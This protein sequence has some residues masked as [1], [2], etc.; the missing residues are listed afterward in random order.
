M[1]INSRQNPADRSSFRLSLLMRMLIAEGPGTVIWKRYAGECVYDRS[2]HDLL[3][4]ILT[5]YSFMPCPNAHFSDEFKAEV[6]ALVEML[7]P[8]AEN[9]GAECEKSE[10][11]QFFSKLNVPSVQHIRKL[12]QLANESK[13]GTGEQSYYAK[14]L[15]HY[16]VSQSGPIVICGSPE[17]FLGYR[18]QNERVSEKDRS[19]LEI[20]L[21]D[22]GYSKEF[23]ISLASNETKKSCLKQ[24]PLETSYAHCIAENF[25]DLGLIYVGRTSR[26]QL[27]VVLAGATHP[28]GT[29]GSVRMAM[30]AGRN[31]INFGLLGFLQ[32]T[33]PRFS[34]V[35]NLRPWIES[36]A[37]VTSQKNWEKEA[38]MFHSST[39]VDAKIE[40]PREVGDFSIFDLDV[41][42]KK[43]E[44]REPA[45]L[46][47]KVLRGI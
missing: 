26:K 4:K 31:E 46:E 16:Y 44:A 37:T 40:Y 41:W 23:D 35:A 28:Y 7:K 17:G 36:A 25:V 32:G 45:K 11:A 14:L 10:L 20:L 13:T 30:D 29:Y 47:I 22:C 21:D 2:S 3:R 19:E 9:N 8:T 5:S 27:V 15:Q 33:S 18:R 34:L 43:L 6:D 24:Y 12:Q 1:I 38:G 39:P 42:E